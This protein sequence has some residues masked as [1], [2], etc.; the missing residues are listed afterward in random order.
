MTRTILVSSSLLD[1]SKTQKKK[2]RERRE[3][4]AEA[5]TSLS[6]RSERSG[7]HHHTSLQVQHSHTEYTQN[8]TCE[9]V[10]VLITEHIHPRAQAPLIVLRPL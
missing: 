6:A 8:F 1:P 10:P 4:P 5:A 9:T 3:T 7:P 2:R